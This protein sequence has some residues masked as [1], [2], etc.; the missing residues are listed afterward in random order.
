M[1]NLCQVSTKSIQIIII[2]SNTLLIPVD[3]PKESCHNNNL[4]MTIQGTSDF[5]LFVDVWVII[6]S[7]RLGR[8]DCQYSQ[9]RA[10]DHRW[11]SELLLSSP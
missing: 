6:G 1:I 3:P 2:S 5:V 4:P 7:S 9:A 11:A 8:I 10:N